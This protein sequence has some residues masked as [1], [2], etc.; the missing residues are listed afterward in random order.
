MIIE[1]FTSMAIMPFAYVIT[2]HAELY[3][4]TV[5]RLSGVDWK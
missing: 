1:Y 5:C 3:L 2:P 4:G